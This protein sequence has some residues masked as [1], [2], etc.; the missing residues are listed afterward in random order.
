[1]NEI[2]ESQSM[3]IADP[4]VRNLA[5]RI[6]RQLELAVEKVAANHAHP[7]RYPLASDANSFERILA[8]RFSKLPVKAQAA[9]AARAMG[10]LD[11]A[12][13]I[14]AR[15]FGDLMAVDLTK[16]T[17]VEAQALALPLPDS[18]KISV[19]HIAGLTRL[20]G[21]ILDTGI[22]LVRGLVFP[23]VPLPE[24]AGAPVPM[25]LKK[26]GSSKSTKL[27]LRIQKVKCIEETYG[28]LWS[29]LGADEILLGG[30]TIDVA[31]NVKKVSSFMVGDDFDSGEQKIY[32]PPKT[33]CTFDLTKGD[34]FPKF[35]FATLVMAEQDNGGFPEFLNDLLNALKGYVTKIVAS[36]VAG[37]EL[38]SFAGPLGM[39]AGAVVGAL[40][41]WLIEAIKEI[42][43]DDLFPPQTVSITIPGFNC[44]WS[45]KK[46]GPEHVLHFKGLGGEYAL[47]FDW[48][49]LP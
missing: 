26:D 22:D 24:G 37:L 44:S 18:L 20:H 15:R 1:M 16:P 5:V 33:F 46:D 2:T 8:M 6:S 35:Y 31:G 32:N 48:Q 25:S 42:W 34:S 12:P 47:T 45:G 39:I 43:E 38:G 13:A 11:A 23:N 19:S 36:A 28:F 9:A 7:E 41:G 40:F 17:A 49:L 4:V 21:Q 30:S 27:A 3:R 29:N 10:R 14:R